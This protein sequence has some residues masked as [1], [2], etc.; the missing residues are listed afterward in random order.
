ME[1]AD[2]DWY[3][4]L[5]VVEQRYAAMF[6]ATAH[7]QRKRKTPVRKLRQNLATLD[8]SGVILR[9]DDTVRITNWPRLESLADRYRL[10]Q[11]VYGP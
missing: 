3:C 7:Q 9:Y 5:D 4:R 8:E 6:P 1:V 10:R 11:V 2:E